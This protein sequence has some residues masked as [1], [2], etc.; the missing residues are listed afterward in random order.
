MTAKPF[1]FVLMPFD[2]AF[3]D[4]YKLGIQAVAHEC[5][6]IAERVD[7]QRFT[8]SMLERIY[9]QIDAADFIVAD[10]TG[11]NPNVF[12]EV[13]YAHARD[14]LCTLLTQSADDIP[15]DLKHHRHIVYGSSI[16]FLKSQ[17]QQEFEWLIAEREKRNTKA[18]SVTLKSVTASLSKTD[19]S[20]TAEVDMKFDIHNRTS[21]KSP[22]IE[23]DLPPAK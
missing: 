19:Y 4:I 10:M 17:L 1:A 15:F 12:Y 18:I 22:E 11:R 23:T 2:S 21:K 16:R 20:A 9:R 3:D 14:K 6:I 5:G 8:E 13:G 7:E